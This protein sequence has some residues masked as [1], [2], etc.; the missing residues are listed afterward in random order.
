MLYLKYRGSLLFVAS[1]KKVGSL[2]QDLLTALESRD[3]KK[4]RIEVP[5]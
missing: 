4:A 3:L 1:E 5:E 2:H